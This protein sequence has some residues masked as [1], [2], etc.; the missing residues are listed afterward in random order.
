VH[1]FEG[2]IAC[3]ANSESEIVLPL[4]LNG[5]VIGVLDIDSPVPD[6]FS[7]VDE[8][9]LIAIVE[10]WLEAVDLPR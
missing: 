7:E 9:G 6:R 3:D 5:S 4:V 2:H 10:A 1:A 8:A